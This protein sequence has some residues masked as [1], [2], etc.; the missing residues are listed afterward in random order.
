M[1][2]AAGPLLP[3]LSCSLCCSLQRWPA[4][5]TGFSWVSSGIVYLIFLATFLLTGAAGL[6]GLTI[7]PAPTKE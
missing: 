6:E 5:R 4:T 3:G 1:R 7:R 2:A